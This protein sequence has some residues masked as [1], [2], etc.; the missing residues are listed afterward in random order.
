M[1]ELITCVVPVHNGRRYLAETLHSILGQTHRPLDLVV[2]DNGSDDGSGDLARSFGSALR[3][4][5]Q[6]D[7]GAPAGRNRG[8]REARGRYVAFCDADDLFEPEK[9]AR[10][11]A[12]FAARPELD[13]SLCTAEYF[14]EPGLEAEQERYAR[15]GRVTGTHSFGT[16]LARGEVFDRVGLLDE[17]QPMADQV[18]WFLRA[19]DAGAAIEVIPDVLVRRRMHP[20]SL[21]HRSPTLDPYLDLVRERL[22]A[23]RARR[24]AA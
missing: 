20:D 5:T 1:G 13:I 6:P 24:G 12:R 22:A 4:V 8:I 14:W 16:M 10:Q 19:A 18:D 21:S 7:L 11:L 2:V 9:L 3:V 17:S 15:A 23:R